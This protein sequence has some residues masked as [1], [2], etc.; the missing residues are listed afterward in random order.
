[1]YTFIHMLAITI[2]KE[3]REAM[4]LKDRRER[5]ITR[6]SLQRGKR[7]KKVAIISKATLGD[8][9]SFEPA[10]KKPCPWVKALVR[11]LSRTRILGSLP[12]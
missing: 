9:L 6:D 3:K 12:F 4:N 8:L 2:S 7:K 1:M 5:V 10:Q 11:L